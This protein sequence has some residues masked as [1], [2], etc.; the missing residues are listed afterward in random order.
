MVLGPPAAPT[1]GSVVEMWHLG[2]NLDL[3]N[4]NLCFTKMPRGHVGVLKLEKHKLGGDG[5]AGAGDVGESRGLPTCGLDGR[6]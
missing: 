6:K 2:P 3:L 1:P 4:E 5:N